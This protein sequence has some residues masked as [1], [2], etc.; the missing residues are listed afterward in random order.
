MRRISVVCRQ[1]PVELSFRLRDARS[2]NID[3]HGTKSWRANRYDKSLVRHLT[4][5]EIA[6]SSLNEHSTWQKIERHARK[7]SPTMV[8]RTNF[9][10]N[11]YDSY[12][13]ARPPP[14]CPRPHFV[15]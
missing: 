14:R 7:L 8:V 15:S 9:N 6:K 2:L 10:N 13:F 3:A 4:G 1:A 12:R 5:G 11:I